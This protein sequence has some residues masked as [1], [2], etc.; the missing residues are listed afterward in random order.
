[1]SIMPGGGI[2]AETV[3]A[4]RSLRPAEIHASCAIAGAET[5]FGLGRARVTSADRVRA[6]KAA[7]LTWA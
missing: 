6:L 3:A 4:L 7:L 1:V 5:P 2:G